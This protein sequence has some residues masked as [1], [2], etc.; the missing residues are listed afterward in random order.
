MNKKQ[1]LPNF[2]NLISIYREV[3]ES[4][5]SEE[6]FPIVPSK[7]PQSFLEKDYFHRKLIE[8]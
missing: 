2:L 1:Y 8:L 6:N 3:I 5:P 4:L 7:N